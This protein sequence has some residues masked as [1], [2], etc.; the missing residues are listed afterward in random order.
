VKCSLEQLHNERTRFPHH[1]SGCKDGAQFCL[2]AA[3]AAA[4]AADADMPREPL[5]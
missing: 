2:V 1:G 5:R 3:R 4:A